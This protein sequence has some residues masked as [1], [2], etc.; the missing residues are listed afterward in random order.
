MKK[1]FTI[2]FILLCSPVYGD[3]TLSGS[4]TPTNTQSNTSGSNTS[5]SG[6]YSA[7][8]TNEYSGAHTETTTNTTTSTT[9]NKSKVPVNTAASPSFSSMSQDVCSVG[10]S[11]GVQLPGVAIS[12]GKHVRDLNCERIKLAKVL[13]DFGMKVASVS[14]LCQD[15]RV[16]EA[17]IHAG[18]PCP[19]EGSISTEALDKWKKYDV[20]RPDFNTYVKKLE[21]RSIID[22]IY[23]EQLQEVQKKQKIL[24]E[25]INTTAEKMKQIHRNKQK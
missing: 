9:N 13:H 10:V 18:T 24:E 20:E 14:I 15:E 23:D 7:E 25:R 8:T 5:I 19:F 4:S 16:F 21:M 11:G 6:G 1:F 17:M 3:T 12:G 2:I 22:S